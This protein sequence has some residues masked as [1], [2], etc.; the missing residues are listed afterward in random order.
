MRWT[1]AARTQL[2]TC[3]AHHVQ[4][5]LDVVTIEGIKSG[6]CTCQPKPSMNSTKSTCAEDKMCRASQDALQ[7]TA[8]H[9]SVCNSVTDNISAG[10]TA[11]VHIQLGSRE[12]AGEQL[13]TALQSS[14]EAVMQDCDLLAA[15]GVPDGT[16]LHAAMIDV[17]P[18]L[19]NKHATAEEPEIR[20]RP[21]LVAKTPSTH[22]IE[23][24]LPLLL[25]MG[26]HMLPKPCGSHANLG[27]FATCQLLRLHQDKAHLGLS[28]GVADRLS[29][30]H[31]LI[32]HPGTKTKA[33][34]G[35]AVQG[36]QAGAW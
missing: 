20:E 11:A 13:V 23:V 26:L 14:P 21:Q 8:T 1:A 32:L 2:R 16:S 6:Q 19:S 34:D 31:W 28:F 12:A 17:T 5:P 18:G 3:L 36:V 7:G 10:V 4:L 25:V 24:Y 30:V 15:V 33:G 27:K 22:L 9:S 35:C 29:T